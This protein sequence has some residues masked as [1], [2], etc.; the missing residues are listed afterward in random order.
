MNKHGAL[1]HCLNPIDGS[2]YLARS[3]QCQ[4]LCLRP[5][6]V[7]SNFHYELAGVIG[8]PAGGRQTY[9]SSSGRKDWQKA[10]ETLPVF[11]DTLVSCCYGG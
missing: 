6:S 11:G 10:C 2:V 4:G 7:L 8:Q 3:Y 5:Y 1:G 9:T